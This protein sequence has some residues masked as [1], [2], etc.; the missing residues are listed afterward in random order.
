MKFNLPTRERCQ[1][2]VKNSEAFYCTQR[3]IFGYNVELYDYRLASFSDFVLN[4]AWELRGLCFIQD[5]NGD[6]HRNILMNKF[7]NLNESEVTICEVKNNSGEILYNGLIGTLEYN[8][9]IRIATKESNDGVWNKQ[10]KNNIKNYSKSQKYSWMLEDI[11]DKE[12]MR[13]QEKRDGSVISFVKFPNGVVKAKSKMSFE[14]EQALAADT[15]YCSDKQSSYNGIAAFVDYCLDNGLVPIFEYTSPFN[16]IVLN[17]NDSELRVI[18]I[19]EAD[20]GRYLDIDETNTVMVKFNVKKADDY[21]LMSWNMLL[22][23]QQTKEDIEGWIVT[24][25]DAQMIKVKTEWYF[26]MHGLTTEGTRENLLVQTILEDRIDDV[27]SLIPDGEKK[28]FMIVT[29]EKVQH[30]FNHL[31]VEYKNLRGLY[32]NKFNEDRK[33]FAM[34]YK[35]H[36]LFGYVMKKLNSSFRDVEQVAEQ[37]VKDYILNRT[38]TLGGAKEFLAGI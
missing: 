29:V 19:R 12:I 11:K 34:K 25:S 15:F 30:K 38:R 28:Q 26:A 22:E 5:E 31:V 27:L 14:S 23:K 10:I 9:A 8:A 20:T 37:G 16:Q 21:R 2:I 35:E 1:E 18:Q 13:I 36:E 7:F 3:N 6:W 4:D 17:Y 32:Y 33:E 24:L